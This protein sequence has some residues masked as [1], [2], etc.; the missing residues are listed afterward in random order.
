MDNLSLEQHATQLGI[1]LQQ[2][3]WYLVTAE[4][5]TGGWIAQAVTAIAGSSGWFEQ[6]FV[7]YSNRSK[8]EMLGVTAD[9][10]NLYGAVSKQTVLAMVEGALLH[11]HAQVGIAVSGVAGPSGGTPEKPV[12]TVWIAYRYPQK[13][14]ANCYHFIGDRQ[15]IR[16]QTV[17]TALQEL[18]TDIR[19]TVVR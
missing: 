5:C 6:G 7:T 16:Q 3:H 13:Q 19:L 8:Q 17:I 2:Y 15:A 14:W 9:N 18:I 11:S 12:G 1:L 4:S 10:L